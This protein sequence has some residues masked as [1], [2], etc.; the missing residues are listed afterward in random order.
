M[1]LDWC[2][3]Q[4]CKELLDVSYTLDTS[5]RGSKSW[6]IPKIE[7]EAGREWKCNEEATMDLRIIKSIPFISCEQLAKPG[8]SN[9]YSLITA[10][11]LHYVDHLNIQLETS[12]L[13]LQ[14]CQC[15]LEVD[16]CP[17]FYIESASVTLLRHAGIGTS[18]E[19]NHFSIEM[20][21]VTD[22]L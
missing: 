17:F 10:K 21:N 16:G 3:S 12:E 19:E 2:M 18:E 9:A 1:V 13:W 22:V 8:I 5:H 14:P 6:I 4:P 7:I 11:L 20:L 15:I